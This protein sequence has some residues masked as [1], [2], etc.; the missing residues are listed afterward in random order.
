MTAYL[1]Y[2]YRHWAYCEGGSKIQG[3]LY[4]TLTNQ[5]KASVKN[6]LKPAREEV[7]EDE[8]EPEVSYAESV[9]RGAELQ[10]RRR[11]S[12]SKYRSTSH[13]SP[14]TN[15]VERANSQAKLIMADRR[16]SLLPQTLNM[17]M[18]VKHNKS[19]WLTAESVQE[20]LDSDDFRDPEQEE[21]DSE[22]EE[23]L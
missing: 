18:I 21:P 20:I 12:A 17:L 1:Y 2:I 15:I 7:K 9:L 14:T 23:G 13:V 19:F 22:E 6:F 10:K 4:S 3:G 8:P 5:E 11:T 16:S